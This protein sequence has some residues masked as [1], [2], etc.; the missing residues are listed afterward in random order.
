[1]KIAV[2][3][4][5]NFLFID[6]YINKKKIEEN[7]STKEKKFNFLFNNF[8]HNILFLSSFNNCE[9]FVLAFDSECKFRKEIY[10]LYKAKR[11][12]DKN[13]EDLELIYSVLNYIYSLNFLNK[14]KIDNCEA[15]DIAYYFVEKNHKE[16]EIVLFSNDK[17]WIQIINDFDN[18]KLFNSK[19][20]LIEKEEKILLKKAI[21]GDKSDNIKGIKGIGEKRFENFISNQENLE[22]NKE[23]IEKNLEIID[24]KKHKEKEKI[25]KIINEFSLLNKEEIKNIFHNNKE[26]LLYYIETFDLLQK[27]YNKI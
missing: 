22:K 23:I 1:M 26:F 14:L 17:D 12:E 27:F 15:D 3:D 25:K 7:F 13:K 19:R 5:S 4:I 21:V 6:F 16:N 18:V 24:I 10:P 8:F 2:F 20:V 11:N 9:N